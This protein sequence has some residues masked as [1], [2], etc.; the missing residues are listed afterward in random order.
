MY[1]LELINRIKDVMVEKK[2]SIAVAESV[3]AGHLQAALSLAQNASMFFNRSVGNRLCFGKD[4]P[5]N[6]V[7]RLPAF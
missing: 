4:R 3:T 2:W 6:G 1:K 5:T 7:E